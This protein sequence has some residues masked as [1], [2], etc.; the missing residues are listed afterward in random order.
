V[1]AFAGSVIQIDMSP[2]NEGTSVSGVHAFAPLQDG[3]GDR[4]LPSSIALDGTSLFLIHAVDPLDCRIQAIDPGTIS[5]FGAPLT[6]TSFGTLLPAGA[7]SAVDG[8]LFLRFRVQ[9]T[10]QPESE[11]TPFDQVRV[12]DV[13]LTYE[14]KPF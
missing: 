2:G 14:N 5:L 6:L 8:E 3:A 10:G 1:D 12:N 11:P 13:Q 7:R 4:V 9:L